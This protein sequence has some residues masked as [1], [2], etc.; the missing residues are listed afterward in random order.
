M[1]IL[2]MG[3][4]QLV[5][6]LLIY[7]I[8]LQLLKLKEQR[9]ALKLQGQKHEDTIMKVSLTHQPTSMEIYAIEGKTKTLNLHCVGI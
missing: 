1:T 2:W 8:F 9:E 6:Y 3:H 5:M 7:S 4:G